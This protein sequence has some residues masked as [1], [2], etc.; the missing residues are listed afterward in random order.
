LNIFFPVGT[1]LAERLLFIPSIGYC[2][3]VADIFTTDLNYVWKW[4]YNYL[5]KC[6]AVNNN[7]NKRVKLILHYA[8]AILFLVPILFLYSIRIITRNIDWNSEIKIYE[9]ALLV[10]PHSVKALNNY[11]ALHM[12]ESYSQEKN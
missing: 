7:N 4:Q 2:F 11:A 8:P 3:L 12:M 1:V 10:C 6:L 9:S 5:V